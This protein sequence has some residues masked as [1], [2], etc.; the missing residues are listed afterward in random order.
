MKYIFLPLGIYFIFSSEPELPIVIKDEFNN[1]SKGWWT[2]TAEGVSMKIENGK[3]VIATF[4]KNSGRYATVSPAFDLTKDFVLEASFVQQSGSINNGFGLLWGDNGTGQ[5]C[6]FLI[7]T[8]GHFKIKN[9]EGGESM[10]R[11]T[12]CQV[13]P[14]GRENILRVQAS[15]GRWHYF[16]NEEEVAVTEA[17]PLYGPRIGV[18]N[19]TDMLLEIDNFIFR[20]DLGIRLAPNL[21]YGIVKESLGPKVNSDYDEVGPHVSVDGRTLWFGVKHSPEN[22]GGVNDGEDTWFTTSVDGKNWSPRQN[23]GTE[24]NTIVT[25]NLA[26]VRADNNT[27]LYCKADGFLVRQRTSTGWSPYKKLPINFSNEA[28][29][30]EAHW[31]ADGGAILFSARMKQNLHYKIPGN[32]KDI[33]VTLRKKGEEWTY[34][35]NIGSSINT[36]GDEISPFLAADGRTL[37]FASN[38][39]RGYGSYDIFMSKRLGDSWT[40]WT[41]PFNLGPEINGPGFDAYFTLAASAHYA[42]VVSTLEANRKGDLARIE[43]PNAMK[44]KPMALLQGKTFHALTKL[45][46]QAELHFIEKATKASWGTALSDPVTGAY[47]HV[48]DQGGYEIE[49]KAKGFITVNEKLELARI[50]KYTELSKDWYLLP[51]EENE[52]IPLSHVFFQQGRAILKSESYPELDRL[53]ALMQDNPAMKIE[54]AG[55]T[56]NVGDQQILLQL[57][58]QRVQAVKEYLVSKGIRKDRIAGKGYGP[59]RPLVPNNSNENRERNRRVEFRIIKK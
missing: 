29:N 36:A 57:S 44:P 47:M 24:I 43:L 12:P 48:L 55:H 21:T 46:I 37:Y 25:D 14:L 50:T 45:P 32:E 1:H 49:V 19:Y 52:V 38:G 20:Q 54:L 41:E 13:H 59:T 58:Q 22:R 35:V 2:G 40:Q 11:W 27:L 39:H 31:S 7:A 42:Y 53:V 28:G 16:I 23:M 17:F 18:I 3:Y 5:R 6:E 33:Y 26:A 56:D 51:I 34:P 8:D 4:S 30:T 10:N 15:G 9:A